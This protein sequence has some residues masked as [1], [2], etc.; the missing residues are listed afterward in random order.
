MAWPQPTEYNEAIQNPHLCFSD[1]ELRQGRAT[2]NPLG[3]PLPRS[4]NFA[5]VYQ[6]NCP[7]TQN[8]WAVKCFTRKVEGLHQR[9]QAISAHLDQANLPFMVDFRYLDEGIRIHG[10][11]YP[12]LKM[13]WVE[14]LTLNEF[15]RDQL[16]NPA[17]LEDLAQ[18]WVKLAQRLQQAGVA[19]GD[20]QHGNVLLIAGRKKGA[21]SLRMIDY[22]GMYVP[23][24]AQIPSGE[25]GH[26]NY[27]H[28]QRLREGTYGPGVDRFAHL[29][30]H[31]ALRCLTVGGRALWDRYDNSDNLLFREQDFQDPGT[32]PLFHELWQLNDPPV[33]SLVGHLLLA[34]ESPVAK[35]PLLEDLM[36]NGVVLPLTAEQE[37]QVQSCLKAGAKTARKVPQLAPGPA[38][39]SVP[40]GAALSGAGSP[41]PSLPFSPPSQAG[42]A[43]VPPSAGA[44]VVAASSG[45]G[46]T[47]AVLAVPASL[48]QMDPPKAEGVG[49]AIGFSLSLALCGAIAGALGGAQETALAG[50]LAGAAWIGITGWLFILL[51]LL[52]AGK[53]PHDSSIS[54]VVIGLLWT[55][56]PA[57][58]GA[59]FGG[60]GAT[61][62]GVVPGAIAGGIAGSVLGGTAVVIVLIWGAL[63]KTRTLIF[64]WNPVPGAM[65][66]R[67]EVQYYFHDMKIWRFAR[68]YEM[69]HAICK[70]PFAGGTI[71]RWRVWA[72]DGAGQESPK[73]DWF[74][75]GYVQS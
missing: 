65:K 56:G 57:L 71:G 18:M 23:A 46:T 41:H 30:I 47:G 28:P 69:S 11:W 33:H 16:D 39:L 9:Y 67:V 58:A 17:L 49:G 54:M 20:L 15:V 36:A 25:V 40:V 48:S 35:V 66:Y 45:G 31:C 38:R 72:I 10:E 4:G 59:L 22:D 13:R 34:V 3:I 74:E 68:L 32:S 51:A 1:P 70:H 6:V 52:Y 61:M 5:D 24:L 2:A 53:W 19:H 7:A 55:L 42:S 14:G 12:L 73:S 60:I 75:F 44:P 43:K 8:S 63:H 29:V 64:I 62:D 27:Q 37:R 50:T 21:L 26:P